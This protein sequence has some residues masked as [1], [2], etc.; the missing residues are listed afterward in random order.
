MAAVGQYV[1]EMARL[2]VMSPDD[3]EVFVLEWVDSLRAEYARVQRYGGAG[4]MGL[5]IVAF[6]DER[7]EDPWDNYQCKHYVGPLMPSDI[8]PELGKL[9]IHT[10]Q[11]DYSLPRRYVFVAPLGAGITVKRLMRDPG[12]LRDELLGHWAGSCENHIAATR[13]PLSDE[14]RAHIESID[15]SIVSFAE[16]LAV[17]DGHATTRWHAARFGGGL[18]VR[19]PDPEPPDTIQPTEDIYVRALLDAY[20]ERLRSSVADAESVS[21]PDLSRHLARSRR[22]FYCAESLREFSRDNVPSGAFEGL[23]DEVDNGVAD[24]A[25]RHYDD[26]YSRVLAVVEQAKRIDLAANALH[27]VARMNDRGG[28]CHQLANARRLT[29]RR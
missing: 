19:G 25:A 8:W 9:A 14:L 10:F 4:D 20:E 13:V 6:V 16:P 24:T 17:L 1:P 21:D 5:D 2:R 7:L 15:F 12:S 29:W 18:P 23:L 28:M 22:E 3:W 26:G 11:G 27:T